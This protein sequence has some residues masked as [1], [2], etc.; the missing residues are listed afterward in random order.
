MFYVDWPLVQVSSFLVVYSLSSNAEVEEQAWGSLR[1]IFWVLTEGLSFSGCLCVCLF[2]FLWWGRDFLVSFLLF[3]MS[4]CI[5]MWGCPREWVK[6]IYFH[7]LLLSVSFFIRREFLE[8]EFLNSKQVQFVTRAFHDRLF[9]LLDS[10][11]GW[12][13]TH[14]SPHA[15]SRV[16]GG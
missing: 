4:V 11:V 12:F 15:V 1:S 6:C 16:I 8:T 7:L 3:G 14:L 2:V 9:F 5:W 10:F 13:P